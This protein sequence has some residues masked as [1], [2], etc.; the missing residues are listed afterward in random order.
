MQKVSDGRCRVVTD[1]VAEVMCAEVDPTEPD[2]EDQDRKYG[3]GGPPWKI[4]FSVNTLTLSL[5]P[6]L[7]RLLGRIRQTNPFCHAGSTD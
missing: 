3:D 6:I 2:E 1:D 4:G 5:A 7:K